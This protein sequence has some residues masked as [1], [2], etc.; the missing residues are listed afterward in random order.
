MTILL[1]LLG[2]LAVAGIAA[3]LV[4]V[5]RDGYGRRAQHRRPQH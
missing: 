4:E 2:V 3:S 5:G 1:T